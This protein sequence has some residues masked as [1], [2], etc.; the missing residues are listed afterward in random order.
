MSPEAPL[1]QRAVLTVRGA[2]ALLFRQDAAPA[3]DERAEAAVQ[4]NAVVV[5]TAFATGPVHSPAPRVARTG[6]SSLVTIGCP[7]VARSRPTPNVS[8]PATSDTAP[9]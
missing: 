1:R 6:R 2:I 9:R 3:S 5:R 8:S 7:P 4:A